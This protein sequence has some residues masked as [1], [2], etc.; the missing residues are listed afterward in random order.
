M[1]TPE[2]ELDPLWNDLDWAI[3]QMFYMGF[4]G[5]EVTPQIRILIEDHHLGSILLTTKNL[6][7]AQQTANL[8]QELQ[9]IAHKA[10]HPVPLL[11]ALDQENGGVNSLFDNDYI[12]QFPSA[13]GVA[14]TG[15]LELAYEVANAT[16]KEL[17]AVGINMIMGPVLDVLT[18][19]RYQPLG[20]RA[21]GDDPQEVSQYGIAAMN[22]YKDAGITTCGKHFPSYGNLDFLGSSLDMPIITETLEQLSLGAL[23]PFRNAIREGLDAMMV[24]G[25][26]IANA[27]MSV[28]HACL[29]DQVVDDLLRGDLG[30]NGVTISECLEMDALNKDIGVRGGTVMAVEAGCDLV[31]LCRSYQ[32]Q[33]EAISG[34][35]LG[36]ENGM[37]SRDRINLSLKRIL[38]LKSKCTSWPQALNPTGIDQ[39]SI[40]HPT[41]LAL[42]TKAYDK[43]ITIMRDKGHILPLSNASSLGDDLLLLTPL[44]KPLPASAATKVVSETQGATTEHDKA[45]RSSIMS[46]EGV[47]RELGRALARQRHGKLLHTSYTANGVRPVHENLINKAATII[48]V[49]ADANRNLY[50]N[51]FTKYVAM[52]CSLLTAGGKKKSLI[53]VSVSSPYDFAMDKDIDTYVCTFD[54]TETAMSALVRALFG[55]FTPSGT[56]PGTLRKSRKVT[57]SRQQ[58][59]VE[60]FD[61]NRDQEGLEE[62]IKTVEKNSPANQFC[63]LAGATAS[64]FELVSVVGTDIEVEEEF[65]YVVRNSSTQAL[66]GFCSTY[67]YQ[68]VGMIGAIFVDPAKRN[69]LIG[70]SLHKRAMRGLL[71]RPG[72]EKIQLGLGLP[73]IYLGIPMS[74]LSEGGRLKCWFANNGW[75]ILSPR[76]LYTLTIRNLSHWEIPEGLLPSIQRVSFSFDLI[77]G[78]DNSDTV[79]DHVRT[80]A[81]PE[82]LAL[83]QLALEDSGCGIVRAKSPVD[84]AL[85][86]TIIICRPETQLSRYMPVLHSS[87]ERERE[88]IGGILAPI[89]PSSPQADIVLQGLALLG[90]KQNKAHAAGTCVLNW[91]QGEQRDVLLQM[92]FD[93]LDAWE[94]LSCVPGKVG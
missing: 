69:L 91:V 37:I 59:L 22:G 49:T 67:F 45:H 78:H 86:G 7:S 19:A 81:G 11:I 71:Q 25:C 34:L 32:V 29:S 41:H 73:G 57:K 58:W 94:E 63:P 12:C 66:F 31:L 76:L 39:L 9:T 90:I 4:D 24:G 16:G 79:L 17:I 6:K 42:S 68:G 93:V 35:K 54:F 65:H 23:V 62:L 13:M 51:S 46:G 44:V 8:V 80:N 85:V 21:T 84:G 43:S 83:Y 14:A 55:E 89:I 87:T 74:D 48:V 77:H 50:Q 2:D 18:N 20:V 26:A 64:S 61:R 36:I 28:M 27:D 40:L 5:T 56:L 30:F 75:D 88:R 10:G 15:S 92:G 60:G 70:H 38:H 72:I 33:L 52:F 1:E 82:V 3:G 47:F 53:V